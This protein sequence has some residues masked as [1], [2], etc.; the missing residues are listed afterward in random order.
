[1]GIIKG[2]TDELL[3]KCVRCGSCRSVCPVFNVTKEEPSVARGKIFLANMINQGKLEVNKEAANIFNLCTT[4][5][6]CQ[7]ICPVMVNYEEIAISSRSLSVKKFGLPI[8]KKI[9]VETM[10]KRYLLNAITRIGSTFQRILFKQKGFNNV[11]RFN[12]PKLGK[13]LIPQ[14]KGR[15]FNYKSRKFEAENEKE[16][17]IFFTGCMFN[18]FYTET[19]MNVVRILNSLG[20]TVIVPEEQFCCGAPAL[21]SGDLETFENLKKKNIEGLSKYGKMKFVTACATCGHV[22]KKEYKEFAVFDL[23]EILHSNLEKIGTW[24]LPSKTKITWHHPCHVVRGQKIPQHYPLDILKCIENLEFIEME[25]SDNCCG[26]G[27]SFK[28]SHPQISAKIQSIKTDNAVN[29]GAEIIT[30][31]CPGCVMNIAEGL[32]RKSARMKSL[33]I[34]DVLVRCLE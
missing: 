18:N 34:A 19:A 17:L 33:H 12:I 24:K 29:T 31:E 3:E 2:I 28:Y 4:C 26:M 15:P 14:M 25:D 9:I 5:L 6:R 23:L 1:M 11:L 7:E 32:E 22:L 21:F 27:G 20:Y 30:T 13:I 16:T 8:E 10:S